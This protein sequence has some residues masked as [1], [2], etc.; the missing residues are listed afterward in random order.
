VR[1][2]VAVGITQALTRTRRIAHASAAGWGPRRFHR[3]AMWAL[4]QLLDD[5][6]RDLSREQL[7][8]LLSGRLSTHEW[9]SDEA[10]L[11]PRASVRRTVW[12]LLRPDDPQTQTWLD[13]LARWFTADSTLY[14]Q[15]ATWLEVS[16]L[17]F[18]ATPAADLPAIVNRMFHPTRAEYLDNSLW[19]LTVPLVNRLRHDPYVVEALRASLSGAP[20]PE[21]T[22]FF[23]SSGLETPVQPGSTGSGSESDQAG[24]RAEPEAFDRL[25]GPVDILGRRVFVTALALKRSGHLSADDLQTALHTLRRASTRLIVVDT[26]VN[27]AGPL[28][29]LGTALL[30][31]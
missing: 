29:T 15:P 24:S 26:F 19:E 30:D 21:T 23:A 3:L 4:P 6:W 25:A 14:R 20:I 2:T 17:C 31:R 12:A 18:G 5:I 11:N 22:P 10:W 27:Q 13:G 7:H 16:A 1:R 8:E 28:W 9:D